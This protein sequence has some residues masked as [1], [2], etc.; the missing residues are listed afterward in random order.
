MKATKQTLAE[1]YRSY[2]AGAYSNSDDWRR[3]QLSR[4]LSLLLADYRERQYL[5]LLTK[6]ECVAIAKK[7]LSRALGREF[8][9]AQVEEFLGG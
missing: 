4:M 2:K 7:L 6:P 5:P 9:R 1:A 3:D 8:T